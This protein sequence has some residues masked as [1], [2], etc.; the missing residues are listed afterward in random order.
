[1]KHFSIFSRAMF[2]IGLDF[3]LLFM[4]GHFIFQAHTKISFSEYVWSFTHHSLYIVI[5]FML[6][7]TPLLLLNAVTNLRLDMSKKKGASDHINKFTDPF[8]VSEEMYGSPLDQREYATPW[9]SP[10]ELQVVEDDI[11]RLFGPEAKEV[12]SK[13]SEIE[14]DALRALATNQEYP[15]DLS[16]AHGTSLYI[17]TLNVWMYAANRYG[18]S[19][20]Y[21]IL[22]ACHDLGKLLAYQLLKTGQWK[23]VSTRHAQLS[24]NVFRRLPSYASINIEKR[25]FYMECFS[26]LLK[27][28]G[29][30]PQNVSEAAILVSKGVLHC[31]ASVTAK[32]K[33]VVA[34][35]A[36]ENAAVQTEAQEQNLVPVPEENQSP[37]ET[38]T[39]KI[40]ETS[41]I[42]EGV[43]SKQTSP[44]VPLTQPV[45]TFPG[46]DITTDSDGLLDIDLN[47]SIDKALESFLY[48][49]NINQSTNKS[50]PLEGIYDKTLGCVLIQSSLIVRK[51]AE[52][53]DIQ[54]VE[55]LRLNSD[56][57]ASIHPAVATLTNIFTEN[58]WISCKVS[59]KI[60]ENGLFF[61]RS[62]RNAVRQAPYYAFF[63]ERFPEDVVSAWVEW[64]NEIAVTPAR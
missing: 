44:I 35:L 31:D 52:S 23:L 16:G 43:P 15:A 63:A 29:V 51:L 27:N 47:Y 10:G 37:L 4:A 46:Q 59:N 25:H 17:H 60:S 22:A 42:K 5:I 14:R 6:F 19:T 26:I 41:T 49:L 24:A 62:G 57:Q 40:Q 8:D 45:E 9:G 7:F 2:I 50:K 64:K 33:A 13:T 18:P 61:V 20:D 53:L 39:T 36:K 32:E 28:Y 56:Q 3:M 48:T 12:L 38:V 21:S 30:K 54:H 55:S 58:A 34:Q 11:V 1:M